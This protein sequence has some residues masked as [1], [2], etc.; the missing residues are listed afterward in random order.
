[1]A[2]DLDRANMPPD[3]L[4]GPQMT[5]A[6]KDARIAEMTAKLAEAERALAAQPAP[7]GEVAL[8]KNPHCDYLRRYWQEGF[9]GKEFAA[10]TGDAPLRAFYDGRRAREEYDAR[11]TAAASRP[12]TAVPEGWMSVQ[13]VEDVRA[14]VD[15]AMTGYCPYHT[16]ARSSM[17]RL[18]ALLSAAPQ[19]AAVK[20]DLTTAH[21]DDESDVCP[22][23][24]ESDADHSECA[25]EPDGV[26]PA[27]HRKSQ[28]EAKAGADDDKKLCAFAH[29]AYRNEGGCKGG[30]FALSQPKP[31]ADAE[32]LALIAD[33]LARSLPTA[34]GD[35]AA[36]ERHAKA[37]ASARRLAGKGGA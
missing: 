32:A 12:A 19:P 1:M 26:Y 28:P 13:V 34:T 22:T 27:G 30:C 21:G 18:A 15:G 23:C 17:R 25:P 14:V 36:I 16:S 3:L 5:Q 20:Q 2:S 35:S 4:S 24:G 9:D 8:P 10:C 11:A 7:D 6:E 29:C 31:A 37:L 33:C